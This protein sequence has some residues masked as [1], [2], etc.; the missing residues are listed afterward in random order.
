MRFDILGL[1]VNTLT[2]NYEYSYSNKENLPLPIQM[3]LPKK[4][5]TFFWIFVFEFS[6]LHSIS[7][8]LKKTWAFYVNYFWSY[9]LRKMR[10]FNYITGFV[11]ENPLAVN[12]STSPK[13]SWNLQKSTFNLLFHHS[14]PNWFRKSYFSW[15]LRF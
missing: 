8:V 13:N 1:L 4:R 6:N 12:A 9:W 7:N 2:A 3:K 11:S 10:L 15:D 14:E 5:S